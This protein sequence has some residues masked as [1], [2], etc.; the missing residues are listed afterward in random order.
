MHGEAELFPQIHP[1]QIAGRKVLDAQLPAAHQ[2]F[3]ELLLVIAKHHPRQRNGH[4]AQH[5]TAEPARPTQQL[6]QRDNEQLAFAAQ[7]FGQ[8]GDGSHLRAQRQVLPI[9]LPGRLM[10]WRGDMLR[11]GKRLW[12]NLSAL[13]GQPV[14]RLAAQGV[15]L[16]CRADQ[17]LAQLGSKGIEIVKGA[18]GLFEASAHQ[19][20]VGRGFERSLRRLSLHRRPVSFPI[21]GGQGDRLI[22]LH[23]KGKVHPNPRDVLGSQVV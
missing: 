16:G 21:A 12:Q 17:A 2:L 20:L 4:L 6:V 14:Q 7:I 3:G 22:C 9:L 10:L 15:E 23:R 5:G 18:A 8:L 19:F 1:A 13:S 11:P